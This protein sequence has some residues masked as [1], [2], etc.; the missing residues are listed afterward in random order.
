MA[1]VLLRTPASELDRRTG[2]RSELSLDVT[3]RRAGDEDII[4]AEITNLSATGFLARFP[5]G[6]EIPAL[7][8]V[9]LPHAGIRTAQVVWNSE[10]MVGCSFTRALARAEISAAQLKSEPRQTRP[11]FATTT[12]SLV[13]DPADPIWDTASEARAGE[14]WSPRSRLLVIGAIATLPWL[15]VAGIIA[16][17]A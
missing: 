4:P 14:K 13:I 5:E 1:S 6:A 17:F 9:E 2:P 10:S 11:Q 16:L 3:L 15:S 7:L 12:A 8:D